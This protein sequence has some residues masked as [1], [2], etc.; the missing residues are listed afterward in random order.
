LKKF[1]GVT[2]LGWSNS[3]GFGPCSV[4]SQGLWC[5]SLNVNFDRLLHAKLCLD[6]K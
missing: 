5:N 1:V 4:S 3:V 6:F 2:Y